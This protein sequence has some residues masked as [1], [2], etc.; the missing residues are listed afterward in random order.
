MFM[1]LYG[2][3]GVR[4]KVIVYKPLLSLLNLQGVVVSVFCF[5]GGDG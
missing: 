3:A 5:E 4:C 2:E 1:L